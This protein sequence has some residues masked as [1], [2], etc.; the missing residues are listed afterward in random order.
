MNRRKYRRRDSAA[1]L[2]SQRAG[3]FALV[4]MALSIFGHRFLD[5][6]TVNLLTIGVLASAIAAI[7]VLLGLWG[8]RQLWVHGDRA[9]TWAMRGLVTAFLTLFPAGWF[10]GWWLTLPA[11]SDVS[12]DTADP[13]AFAPDNRSTQLDGNALDTLPPESAALQEAAYPGVVARR[14]TEPA[15]VV[16]Q[17]ITQVAEQKGWPLEPMRGTPGESDEVFIDTA[18]RSFIFGFHF[19]IVIRVTD[20]DQT[21]YVDMRSASHFGKHDF[22]ANARRIEQFLKDLDFAVATLAN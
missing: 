9:G 20:E 3:I 17:A 1:A 2:W 5:M 11:I 19:S 13:P 22:G 21:T 18:T 12:T 8:L 7:A 4:L 6:A 14:Y 16:I 15:D 10:G